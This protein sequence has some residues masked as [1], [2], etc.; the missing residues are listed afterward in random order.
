MTTFKKTTN[1]ITIGL[2]TLSLQGC[3]VAAIG[4]GVG[5]WKWGDAKK[6]EA[7]TKCKKEYPNYYTSMEKINNSKR[8]RHEK[9]D[10]IMTLNEYCH[11]EV[12]EEKPTDKKTGDKK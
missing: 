4:A 1:L 10:P 7:E 12:K 2:V 6:A 11:I 3:I 9:I 5:S 8:A